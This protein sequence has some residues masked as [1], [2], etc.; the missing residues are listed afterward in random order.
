M[1]GSD[2]HCPCFEHDF[3][4]GDSQYEVLEKLFCFHIRAQLNE[5]SENTRQFVYAGRLL[6][7]PPV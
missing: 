2:I 3:T 1:Y 5:I 4:L 7:E 6:Y